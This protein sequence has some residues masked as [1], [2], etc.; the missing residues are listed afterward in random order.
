MLH[1]TQ[2]RKL[3]VAHREALQKAELPEL[4]LG[5]ENAPLDLHGLIAAERRTGRED[6][7]GKLTFGTVTAHHA[8]QITADHRD[9]PALLNGI[10]HD[11]P[12]IVKH[13]KREGAEA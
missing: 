2:D 6:A 13:G 7:L 4:R 8:Q 10:E 9:D 1:L 12:K 3:A 5:A 11:V